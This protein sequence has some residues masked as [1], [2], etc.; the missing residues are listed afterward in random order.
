MSKAMDDWAKKKFGRV[1]T[2][3]ELIRRCDRAHP[4]RIFDPGEWI[5]DEKVEEVLQGVIDIHIHGAPMGGKM[6]GRQ[7]MVDICIA[8]SEAGMK[9]LVFKDHYTMTS[10]AATIVNK[11]LKRESEHRRKQGIIQDIIY[12]LSNGRSEKA[13]DF[14]PVEVYGGIVLNHTVGGISANTVKEALNYGCKEVWLPSMDAMHQMQAQECPDWKERGIC[15][16]KGGIGGEDLTDDMI[17]VLDVM[18]EYNDNTK[19]N[20]VSLSTCHVSNEEKVAILKYVKKRGMNIKVLMDHV[21]QEMTMVTP[22]EAK[23]MID[24]GGYL[25]FAECS[26]IPWAGMQDW[27]VAFDYS[28]GLIKELIKEKGPEHIVLITDAGQCYHPPIPGWKIFLKTLMAHGVSEDI[29]NV[30]AKEVPASIIYA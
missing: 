16:T 20:V 7:D 1:I 24:L 25:E 5:E 12:N 2:E 18:A 14:V 3:E 22:E 10:N 30:M 17:A 8:A 11:L 21:T 29:V 6:K 13:K 23:E 15:V 19:G 9:A 26:I 27:I 4:Y 28:I